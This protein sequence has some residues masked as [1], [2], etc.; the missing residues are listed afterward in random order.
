M[1]KSLFRE[2]NS[3]DEAKRLQCAAAKAVKLVKE[4]TG[5]DEKFGKVGLLRCVIAKAVKFVYLKVPILFALNLC[6]TTGIKISF[7]CVKFDPTLPFV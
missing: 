1:N 5:C 3:G 2:I 7:V 6:L 4:V